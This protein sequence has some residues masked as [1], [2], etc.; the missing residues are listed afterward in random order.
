MKNLSAFSALEKPIVMGVS[1]KST[2]GAVLDRTT[3]ER[4][5][6]SLALAAL[7]CQQGA[8]II[9]AHD[10]AATVDVVKMCHAVQSV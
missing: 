4:L 6:G 1:R 2:I 5:A 3:E 10:V 8:N 9:R 7:C